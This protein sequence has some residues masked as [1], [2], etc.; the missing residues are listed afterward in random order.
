MSLPI[1]TTITVTGS[2]SGLNGTY[3]LIPGVT[4]APSAPNFVSR[5]N[6]WIKNPSLSST[7]VYVLSSQQLWPESCACPLICRGFTED[8]VLLMLSGSE[9]IFYGYPYNNT[10]VIIGDWDP[11]FNPLDTKFEATVCS[12]F[13][14]PEE[15][16]ELGVC[17]GLNAFIPQMIGQ[18]NSNTWSSRPEFLR[19][20]GGTG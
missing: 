4:A 18:W 7:I 8:I 11:L 16:T 13:Y 15:Q 3:T 17:S 1:P 6:M 9:Q 12:Y 20:T 2:L 10:N 5:T 19:I 14:G